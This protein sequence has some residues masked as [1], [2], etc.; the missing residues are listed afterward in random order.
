MCTVSPS[1][2]FDYIFS[3]LL[4]QIHSE[5]ERLRHPLILQNPEFSANPFQTIRIH[6]QNTLLKQAPTRS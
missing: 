6:A 3:Q 5:L 4:N 1:S 2:T